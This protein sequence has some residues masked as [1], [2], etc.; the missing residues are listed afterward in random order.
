MECKFTPYEGKEPYVFVSYCHRDEV[1]V[2]AIL[3]RLHDAGLRIWYDEGIEWGSE[4]P[5]EIEKHL[6]GSQV[7]LAFYSGEFVASENCRQEVHFALDRKK[8]LLPVYLEDV[9]LEFGLGLRSSLCQ[10]INYWKLRDKERFY[11]LLLSD[12]NI[13]ACRD[14]ERANS[15]EAATGRANTPIAL[16]AEKLHK[17]MLP[18]PEPVQKHTEHRQ[19]RYFCTECGSEV[20]ADTVLFDMSGLLPARW[21][22]LSLLMTEE[23]LRGFQREGEFIRG[24][25]FRCTMTL[26]QILDCM[27]NTRNLKIPV[28]AELTREEIRQFCEAKPREEPQKTFA[29]LLPLLEEADQEDTPE[30][31]P[32]VWPAGIRVLLAQAREPEHLAEHSL[33]A[34]LTALLQGVG[35]NGFVTFTLELEQHKDDRGTDVV[36]GAIVNR[37]TIGRRLLDQRVCP[38]CK[39]PLYRG[40][41]TA[42]HKVITF[43]GL[44]GSGKTAVLQSLLHYAANH[45]LYNTNSPVWEGVEQF[46]RVGSVEFLHSS[47]G[48]KDLEPY[49]QGYAPE[50]RVDRDFR[51]TESATLRI[52]EKAGATVEEAREKILTLVELSQGSWYG[53]GKEY[54]LNANGILNA[55]PIV[56]SSDALVVC[57]DASC[58]GATGEN[59]KESIEKARGISYVVR[60]LQHMIGQFGSK[61]SIPTMLLFT[62][63]PDLEDG[64]RVMGKRMAYA[65]PAKAAYLLNQERGIMERDAYYGKMIQLFR[66]MQGESE[67]FRAEMRCTALGYKAPRPE[68][69]PAGM[70]ELAKTVKL[71]RPVNMDRLMQWLL[72]VS[73]CI[74][75]RSRF[76]ITSRITRKQYRAEN[77]LFTDNVPAEAVA[78]CTLF[79]NPGVHDRHLMEILG[80]KAALMMRKMTMKPNTNDKP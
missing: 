15:E 47:R 68:Q 23:E 79:S 49:G 40:A 24:R 42:E 37:S 57:Q 53:A 31:A 65:Q 59:Q 77:P 17:P 9:K 8:K 61:H 52:R 19:Y 4:W 21:N 11:K 73:G 58:R 32:V 1:L 69:V 35:E 13:L 10:A 18:A 67:G 75:V 16:L 55:F 27:A 25:E 72:M 29:D 38:C 78:R 41:G 39:R 45:M 5:Y 54:R 6:L 28:L 26:G 2:A 36:T 30:E 80:Q 50:H 70:E 48:L 64:G 7:C 62:K 44:P 3:N 12:S 46:S 71:P 76:G 74:E 63:C 66:D 60:D 56:L 20:N 51:G 34:D 33:R 22:M 43:L 14:P